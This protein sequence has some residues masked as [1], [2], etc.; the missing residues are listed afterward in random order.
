[1]YNYN[2][3]HYRLGPAFSKCFINSYKFKQNRQLRNR[4]IMLW[5]NQ[6]QRHQQTDKTAGP[7]FAHL[8]FGNL[9]L[10][11]EWKSFKYV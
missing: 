2:D 10:N 7:F 8:R 9:F 5:K 4:K 3:D 6:G 11:P 1:M